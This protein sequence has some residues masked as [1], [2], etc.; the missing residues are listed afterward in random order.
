MTH[1]LRSLLMAFAVVPFY[2]SGVS[3]QAVKEITPV[4]IVV[5]DKTG[6][7]VPG[8]QIKLSPVPKTALK[9]LE[10]GE[11]GALSMPLIPGAFDLFVSHPLFKS[12]GRHIQV[13]GAAEQ[14][15]EVRLEIAEATITV[16]TCTPCPLIQTDGAPK[17]QSPKDPRNATINITVTNHDG[18]AVPYAQIDSGQPLEASAPP[19]WR[20]LE[21]DEHGNISLRVI[22]GTF[23]LTVTSPGLAR[24]KKSATLKDGESQNVNVVLPEFAGPLAASE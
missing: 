20:V 2:C 18:A 24:W 9:K 4:T 11:N 22:P 19:V 5:I 6:A 12:W 23:D 14:T 10:T 8:A 17:V 7:T 21:A 3:S 1:R 15:I 13:R 16:Q